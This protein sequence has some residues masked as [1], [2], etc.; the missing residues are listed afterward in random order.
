MYYINEHLIFHRIYN[1]WTI[2]VKYILTNQLLMCFLNIIL[3][4][5]RINR[6]SFD[7]SSI[8]RQLLS[9]IPKIIIMRKILSEENYF[10]NTLLIPRSESFLIK[11]LICVKILKKINIILFNTVLFFQVFWVHSVSIS[12]EISINLINAIASF[13]KRAENIIE[14]IRKS[15]Y[16]INLRKINFL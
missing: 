7:I 1:L 3:I 4:I 6:I 5:H 11:I 10:E 13:I 2:N 8:I 16:L 15:F 12:N 9:Y 14:F